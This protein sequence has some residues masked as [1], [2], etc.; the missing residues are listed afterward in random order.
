MP[1][2]DPK[3]P[4]VHAHDLRAVSTSVLLA[5][6]RRLE[7]ARHGHRRLLQ[8]QQVRQLGGKRRGRE[9][10]GDESASRSLP[11]LLRALPLA[12]PR[13]HAPRGAAD[14]CPQPG[15]RVLARVRRAEQWLHHGGLRGGPQRK[16]DAQVDLRLRVL[17]GRKGRDLGAPSVRDAAD[18]TRGDD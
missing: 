11:P 16:A 18:E 12:R 13:A 8:L 3:E 4:G 17:H 9:N 1:R 7:R 10:P 14:T 2:A 15:G 5:L 6:P